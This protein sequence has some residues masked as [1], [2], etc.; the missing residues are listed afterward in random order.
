MQRE[1]SSSF[2]SVREF[3]ASRSGQRNEAIALMKIPHLAHFKRAN[4]ILLPSKVSSLQKYAAHL[5]SKRWNNC[6][7]NL[8]DDAVREE[9]KT[10]E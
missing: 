6:I 8:T 10:T 5:P 4:D 9:I 2:N 7:Y 1:I 3:Q